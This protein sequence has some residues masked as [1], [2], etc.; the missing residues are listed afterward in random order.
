MARLHLY[1][2]KNPLQ[3][4]QLSGLNVVINNRSTLRIGNWKEVIEEVEAG[5]IHI[6][7][8]M[9]YLGSEVGIARAEFDVEQDDEVFVTYKSP[10]FVTS[11]GTIFIEKK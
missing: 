11:Q 4:M 3:W 5:K 1:Y 2:K 7:M 9:P 6:Q 8:S 10:F